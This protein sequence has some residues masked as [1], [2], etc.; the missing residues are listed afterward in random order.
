M[1]KEEA[2]AMAHLKNDMHTH[3]SEAN[4]VDLDSV[5]VTKMLGQNTMAF[6]ALIVGLMAGH[7]SILEL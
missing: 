2:M 5:L 4:A 1:V 6:Q 7:H 3:S